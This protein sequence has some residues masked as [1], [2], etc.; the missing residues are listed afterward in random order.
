M[1]DLNAKFSPTKNPNK[2]MAGPGLCDVPTTIGNLQA[3]ANTGSA[4]RMPALQLNKETFMTLSNHNPG[5]G[6]TQITWGG[7]WWHHAYTGCVPLVKAT[8]LRGDKGQEDSDPTDPGADN[9]SGCAL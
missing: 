1:I 9:D 7:T 2:K 8:I 5:G 3:V 4:M 6:G